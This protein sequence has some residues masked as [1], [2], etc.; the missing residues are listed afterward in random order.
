[1]NVHQ[2]VLSALCNV[3]CP[4]NPRE[5][6]LSRIM[7]DICNTVTK[8]EHQ[9]VIT[10]LLRIDR[11]LGNAKRVLVQGIKEPKRARLLSITVEDT[12]CQPFVPRNVPGLQ[13]DV[14]NLEALRNQ[15]TTFPGMSQ[16][17]EPSFCVDN[18]GD[19]HG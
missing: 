11:T 13:V 12:H 6:S 16:T 5:I 2:E 7:S 9:R 3:R 19:G 8:T 4:G 15:D 10:L 1:M 14:R 18:R 17:P